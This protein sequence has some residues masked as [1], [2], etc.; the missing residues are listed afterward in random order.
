M[1]GSL[2]VVAT[3]PA[4]EAFRG[5]ALAP[6]LPGAPTPTATITPGGPTPTPGA[7]GT[8]FVPPDKN[9]SS[10]EGAVIKNL[11]KLAGC[12][13]TCQKKE[14]D[15]GF[16]GK[17]FDEQACQQGVGKPSSCRAVYNTASA[18]LLGKGTCPTCLGAGAQSGLADAVMTFLQGND[19]QIYC[20]GTTPFNSS[21]TGFVPP[22]QSSDKC[23]DAVMKNLTALDKC[24]TTCQSKQ[25]DAAFK[26]KPFDE[27]A[28]EQGTGKPASCLTKYETA[29]AKTV[30]CPTCLNSV[31]QSTV[32]SVVASFVDENKG[33]VYCAG[34]VPLSAP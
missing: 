14:A 6:G 25:A 29:S 2:S 33:A 17:P 12:V 8:G 3:A 30:N 34:T 26:G 28:C 19:G 18:K 24:M 23:E 7:A 5:V 22:D 21:D 31:A 10:C 16:K 13:M 4:N 11:T 32:A 15:A 1:S 9:T 27:L 20:A